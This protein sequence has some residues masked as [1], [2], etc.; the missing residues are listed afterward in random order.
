LGGG[1][2]LEEV[3]KRMGTNRNALYKL[4]HDA[5][6]KLKKQLAREGLQIDE[7]LAAFEE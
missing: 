5:R 3:A 1:M 2:A 4:L 7:I 6:K